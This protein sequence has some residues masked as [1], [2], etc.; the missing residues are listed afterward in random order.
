MGVSVR[1]SRNTRVYVPWVIAIPAYLIWAAAYLVV[2]A[3]WVLWFLLWQ[4]PSTIVKRR[5]A[6]SAGQRAAHREDRHEARH[7]RS[8]RRQE[9]FRARRQRSAAELGEARQEAAERHV[10]LSWPVYGIIAAGAMFLAGVVFAGVAG[11]SNSA[12]AD[13]AGALGLAAIGTA[14]VC[15]P[16]A[17]WRKFQA[18]KR[19]RTGPLEP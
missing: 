12:L 15:V 4:V 8:D 6:G 16:V 1:V 18:R 10:T 11:S 14:A 5:R 19:A 2:I 9:A 3:A 13:A 17:L 7:E